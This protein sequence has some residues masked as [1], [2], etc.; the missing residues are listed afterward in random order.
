MAEGDDPGAAAARRLARAGLAQLGTPLEILAEDLLGEEDARIDWVAAEPDGRVWVGLVA[1]EGEGDALLARGLAQ[2][3]WVR[4]RL[5][6]WQKLAPG[7]R[8]R[9]DLAPRLALLA[10]GA[11]RT[12]RAAAREADAGGIRLVELGAGTAQADSGTHPAWTD[13]PRSAASRPS[14]PPSCPTAPDRSDAPPP[15]GASI[16]RSGLS[17]RDF[18]AGAGQG[19]AAEG[20]GR[21]ISSPGDNF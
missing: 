1:R 15:A 18:E 12:L 13:P 14:E 17:E 20:P 6:D 4:A 3:A 5:R 2:R 7:L 11:S 10:P 16:F 21:R 19:P 9:L 8:V